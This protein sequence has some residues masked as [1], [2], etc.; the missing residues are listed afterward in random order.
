MAPRKMMARAYLGDYCAESVGEVGE[1][2]GLVSVQRVDPEDV[3][4]R[5]W[6]SPGV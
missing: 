1:D 3:I 5:G 2:G 4:V 6:P